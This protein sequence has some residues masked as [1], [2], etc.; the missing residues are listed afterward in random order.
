M[1][2]PGCRWPAGCGERRR[3]R[4]VCAV[5]AARAAELSSVV[6]GPLV[7]IASLHCQLRAGRHTSR[8]FSTC[9][10]ECEGGPGFFIGSQRVSQRTEGCA[11]V[12]HCDTDRTA[13]EAGALGPE[14]YTAKKRARAR[15]LP[16]IKGV[17]RRIAVP[18][19]TTPAHT[20]RARPRRCN[21]AAE[22]TLSRFRSPH[23]VPVRRAVFGAATGH[24][25]T[26]H[27]RRADA[28]APL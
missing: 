14:R 23:S 26:E 24:T 21:T 18:S 19:P 7:S 6:V 11:A 5:N 22:N 4:S 13:R 25:S 1:R 8:R 3:P 16:A 27:V 17:S 9:C 2:A 10:H 28:L 20:R 12:P 15:V